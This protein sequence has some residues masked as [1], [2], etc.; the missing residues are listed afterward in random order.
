MYYYIV[1]VDGY[2]LPK[3]S[4][5][6]TGMMSIHKNPDSYE[7]PEEFNPER[8]LP[9]TKSMHS[10]ASGKLED[11]DHFNF[12]WGRRICAGIHLVSINNRYQHS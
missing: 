4:I 10:A 5:L 12:G 11:R 7:N 1:I 3:G 9:N 6:S 8:F 2:L